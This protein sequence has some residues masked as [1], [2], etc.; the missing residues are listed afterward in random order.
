MVNY[1]GCK[2]YCVHS[3]FVLNTYDAFNKCTIWFQYTFV[4]PLAIR[5]KLPGTLSGRWKH[6]FSK[7]NYLR[8][9]SKGSALTGSV[10]NM[11]GR[12]F[13]ETKIGCISMYWPYISTG[14]SGCQSVCLIFSRHAFQAIL[15]SPYIS[16]WLC[17]L[18][19]VWLVAGLH[20]L[21]NKTISNTYF[22][23]FV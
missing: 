5:F 9:N 3:T 6:F 13:I 11:P 15:S 4:K 21:L 8:L 14:I 23:L 22:V 16:G 7:V 2:S 1:T 18:R 20:S 10:M 12:L 17:A 19:I